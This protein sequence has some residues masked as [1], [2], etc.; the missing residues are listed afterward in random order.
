MPTQ[1]QPRSELSRLTEGAAVNGEVF[2]ADALF[3]EFKAKSKRFKLNGEVFDVPAPQLWP[4]AISRAEHL[5]EIGALIL[6]EDHYQRYAAAGGTV[7]FLQDMVGA[8][9]NVDMGKSS[10]SSSS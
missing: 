3:A 8:L 9:H 10:A 7:R 5:D 6:G 4:D 2:D 1:Q